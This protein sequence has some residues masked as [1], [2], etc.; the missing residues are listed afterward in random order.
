M[1]DDPKKESWLIDQ[2]A[3]STFFHRKLHDYG[4]LEIAEAIERIPG[5]ALNWDL[6][7]LGISE[8]AWARVIHRGIKPI[9]LFAHPDVLISLPRSVGY[10]RGLA[11]VSLKSMNGIHL[12]VERFESGRS[13]QP[14]DAD[15]AAAVARRLNTL[16][17]HLI[18]SDR[19][20][21]PR[22]FDLW[23][24]MTAGATA[25]G[26]WQNHKGE[27]TELLV[28]EKLYRYLDESGL[29]EEGATQEANPLRLR[30]GRWIRFAS[31]PDLALHAADGTIQ[32]AVEIKGGIDPAGV[33]ERIGAAL[34][35]L[36]RIKQENP[37]AR[38]ILLVQAAAWTEQAQREL[39][40]H[41][42]EIDEWMTLEAVLTQEEG[43]LRFVEALNL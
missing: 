31:E 38:T 6:E 15:K 3:R 39:L 35:S 36:S 16:V 13:R 34:K 41:S 27:A 14:M 17:S 37:N 8:R 33:L 25:Q 30:D 1:T 29:L 26:A 20:I 12:S 40:A 42:Q 43:F 24:G 7:A 21:N 4:L 28:R 10:Y 2:M 19:E 18:E 22:E 11:M 9:R 5:E 32:A 23:R